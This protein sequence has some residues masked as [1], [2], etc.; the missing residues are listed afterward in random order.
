M[1]AAGSV[2][3]V[4]GMEMYCYLGSNYAVGVFDVLAMIGLCTVLALFF[5]LV[6]ICKYA[7]RKPVVTVP[8]TPS[9][10]TSASIGVNAVT[11]PPRIF[12]SASIAGATRCY[13]V[14]GDCSQLKNA[15]SLVKTAQ[16]CKTCGRSTTSE[17]TAVQRASSAE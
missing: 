3:V 5:A 8:T 7:R 6:Y 11:Y 4:R 17:V 9:M 12:V 1:A 2:N 10:S 15:K 14:Q 16:L 13:H